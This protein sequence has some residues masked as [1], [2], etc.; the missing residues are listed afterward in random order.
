MTR[1]DYRAYDEIVV[2]DIV[3]LGGKPRRVESVTRD[4]MDRVRWIRVNRLACGYDSYHRRDDGSV[5]SYCT[6]PVHLYHCD[7]HSS[8]QYRFRGW[9]KRARAPETEVFWRTTEDA[10]HGPEEEGK[11]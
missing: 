2:G 5:R 7:L 8:P 9:F 3:D 11:P 4:D 10:A 1:K 6:G